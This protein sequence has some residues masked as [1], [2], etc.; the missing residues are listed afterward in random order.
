MKE[1]S[2]MSLEELWKLFP[3]K[4]TEYNDEWNKWYDDEQENL[5][6]ILADIDVTRI[7]HIG[8][9]AI[10]AIW[11]NQQLIFLLRSEQA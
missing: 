10:K 4:L 6:K 3:V 2:E 1:L 9:N 8:S 11:A 5:R 7:S